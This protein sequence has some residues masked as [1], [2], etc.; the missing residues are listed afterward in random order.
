MASNAAPIAIA[1][2]SGGRADPNKDPDNPAFEPT[3]AAVQALFDAREINLRRLSREAGISESAIS[4]FL[5]RK[6]SNTR[7][8][9]V[10]ARLDTWM[11]TRER[12]VAAQAEFPDSPGFR[13]TATAERITDVFLYAHHAPDIGGIYCGVGLGKTEAAKEYV[14]NN[15]G[16][17]LATMSTVTRTP[18][19][20]LREI[21]KCMDMR[22][23]RTQAELYDSICDTVRQSKGLL[24]IDEANHLTGAAIDQIR[25]IHDRANV[26]IVLMGNEQIYAGMTRLK[27]ADFMAQSYTRVGMWLNLEPNH[28]A[29]LKRLKKDADILLDAWGNEPS[30]CRTLLHEVTQKPGALRLMVKVMRFAKMLAGDQDLAAKHIRIARKKMGSHTGAVL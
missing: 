5:N 12:R 13:L 26:G 10:V 7:Y 6:A 4:Q 18:M 11:Q 24:I 9:R 22:Q 15:S 28:P 29:Y 23:R 14:R 19:A 27:T 16:V 17:C 25:A 1:G 20:A 8:D 21:S 2:S 30:D 3:R